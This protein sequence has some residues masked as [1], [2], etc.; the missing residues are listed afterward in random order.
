MIKFID[1]NGHQISYEISYDVLT[2]HSGKDCNDHT[3]SSLAYLSKIYCYLVNINLMVI[4]G[5][6]QL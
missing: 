2:N 5:E 3:V 1:K 4:K 6:I